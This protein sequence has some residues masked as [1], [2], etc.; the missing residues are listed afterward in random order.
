MAPSSP[1]RSSWISGMII[2]F[3]WTGPPSSTHA[4]MGRSSTLMASQNPTSS[5][6]KARMPTS[7][8]VPVP[9]TGPPR[10]LQYIGAY[11]Q[12]PI[13]QQTSCHF[14][15]CTDQRSYFPLNY[16]TSTPRSKP[17]NRSRPSRHSRMPST[18]FKNRGISSLQSQLGTNR[19]SDGTTPSTSYDECR[20]RKVSTSCPH[21]RRGHIW[22]SR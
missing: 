13:G 6:R 14:L 9:G 3:G 4:R 10:F 8:S 1:G 16:N 22:W 17:A 20:P 11:G 19:H 15:Q 12:H 21:P 5:P 7:G 2:T 18:S